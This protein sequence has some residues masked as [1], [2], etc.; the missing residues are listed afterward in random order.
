MNSFHISTGY[1]RKRDSYSASNTIARHS[2]SLSR[3]SLAEAIRKCPSRSKF[4][5]QT[6]MLSLSPMNLNPLDFF[7]TTKNKTRKDRPNLNSV[8]TCGDLHSSA[9]LKNS[10]VKSPLNSLFKHKRS[11]LLQESF[12]SKV[13]L[14]KYKVASQEKASEEAKKAALMVKNDLL[15]LLASWKKHL[16]NFVTF[17]EKQEE[18]YENF[19]NYIDFVQEHDFQL[20]LVF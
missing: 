3:V 1:K 7:K 20:I 12:V 10:A 19:K 6:S 8:T 11:K 4:P 15:D 17:T 9:T 16:A 14:A 5:K 18:I 13:N 2:S